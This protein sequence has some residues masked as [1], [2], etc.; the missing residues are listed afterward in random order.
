MRHSLL[1]P[2][3]GIVVFAASASSA[4]AQPPA[5]SAASAATPMAV[6]FGVGEKMQYEVRFGPLKVGE[7]SMEVLDVG[8]IRGDAAWHTRFRV[9]G[10]V[11]FYRVDD[12]LESWIRV[13]DFNSLRFVQDLEEG[14]KTRERRFEIFPERAIFQENDKPEE[15]SVAAPLDDGSFLYFVRTIPLEEGKS[16]EFNRYFRP[17]RNPVIVKVIGREKI[18]VPAGTYNT[19]VIQPVIKSKGIFSEKGQAK[20]WLSDDESRIMVQ[21]KSHTS[22]GS[23]NLYLQSHRPPTATPATPT[24]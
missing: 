6:P 11:P 16:Y 24:R 21:M 20:I 9:K 4:V 19:I 8:S 22:V 3:L 23:L 15:S 12:M 17:D 7:G 18:T 13:S 5:S 1:A 2:L 14:G 10:G